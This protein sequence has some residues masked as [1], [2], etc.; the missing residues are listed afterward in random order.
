[1]ILI[2]F[3]FAYT[4]DTLRDPSN[5]SFTLCDTSSVFHPPESIQLVSIPDGF[6]DTVKTNTSGE[7]VD[8]A[9]T[10]APVITARTKIRRKSSIQQPQP[11]IHK[12]S[13][14][15]SNSDSDDDDQQHEFKTTSLYEKTNI[16]LPDL[17]QITSNLNKVTSE[18]TETVEPITEISR[19]ST[20]KALE[21]ISY[22]SSSSIP[23]ISPSNSLDKSS[24]TST[25]TL[26][27]A[28][29]ISSVFTRSQSQTHRDSISGHSILDRLTHEAKDMAREAKAVAKEV[30]AK[31]AAQAGKK[32]FLAILSVKHLFS[33]S[34]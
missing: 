12:S 34:S 9:N 27:K 32:K 33:S 16:T 30:V 19:S 2:K 10:V 1:M 31:P 20:P 26:T 25:P 8:I 5:S 22:T 7:D 13:S 23:N 6:N 17:N 21:N 29:S 4:T 28:I 24:G 3:N 11:E 15:S 14:S 18:S